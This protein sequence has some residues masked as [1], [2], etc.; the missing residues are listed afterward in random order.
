MDPALRRGRRAAVENFTDRS[1]PGRS[2]APGPSVASAE[3]QG[4]S[5]G[6]SQTFSELPPRMPE[7]TR[8]DGCPCVI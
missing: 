8:P 5:A 2:L 6:P 1:R 3:I 4:V 7:G